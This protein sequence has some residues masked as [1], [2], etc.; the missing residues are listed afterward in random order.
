MNKLNKLKNLN[1]KIE[2]AYKYSN[3]QKVLIEN[4]SV[5]VGSTG[6]GYNSENY[7]YQLFTLTSVTPNLGGIGFVNYSLLEH[8]TGSELPGT[9]NSA[10]SSGK[11][12]AQ[13]H[14]PIFDITLRNNNY[15]KGEVVTSESAVGTVEDWDPKSN[16]VKIVSKKNFKVGDTITGLSSK[17]QGVALS[18]ERFDA[19]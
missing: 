13:K 4:I 19:F 1:L 14:F 17:T 8:L 7:N 9:F 11:I 16:L 3:S 18:I 6:K 2:N 15:F 12:I 5:G 10:N